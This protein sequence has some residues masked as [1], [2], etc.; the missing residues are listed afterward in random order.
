MSLNLKPT[1]RTQTLSAPP[2]EANYFRG[3]G[4][5]ELLIR[6]TRTVLYIY[7]AEAFLFSD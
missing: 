3:S 7:Y 6:G 1:V 5:R 2:R 4:R